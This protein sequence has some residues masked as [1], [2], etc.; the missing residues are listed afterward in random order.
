V[1]WRTLAMIV[2]S[3][4]GA[5]CRQT[6]EPAEGLA[7]TELPAEVRA[8]YEVFAQRCSKC[9][10][11]ARPLRSGITD[12]GF[13]KEYVERMRRQASSGISPSDVEPILRFL[14]YYS[15]EDRRKHGDGG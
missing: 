14:H 1:R 4:P 10:S 15:L 12:D 5:S 2:A 3:W 8:D 9:H 7:E 11:L 6:G 13:W